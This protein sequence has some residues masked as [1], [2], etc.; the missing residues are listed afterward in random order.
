MHQIEQTV[1]QDCLGRIRRRLY[2]VRTAERAA[3]ALLWG[4]VVG[5]DLVLARYLTLRFP[6]Y[7][8]LV[9]LVPAILVGAFW[10]GRMKYE[11]LRRVSLPFCI[12]AGSGLTVGAV[13]VG[14]G[15]MV[16]GAGWPMW[17]YCAGPLVGFLVAAV[18]MGRVVTPQAA[19]IF[20]DQQ[21]GLQERV[22]TAFELLNK[23]VT[24]VQVAMFQAPL[25]ASAAEACREVRRARVGYARLDRRVYLASAVCMAAA[26]GVSFM[27][28]LSALGARARVTRVD[29]ATAQAVTKVA[30]MLD[31]LARRSESK[32]PA[33][34][35]MLVPLE[36]VLPALRNGELSK[37]EAMSAL[38]EAQREYEKLK[39]KYESGNRAKEAMDKDAALKE[40]AKAADDYRKALDKSREGKPGAAAEL[41]QAKRDLEAAAKAAGDKLAGMSAEERAKLEQTLKEAQAAA[42][43]NAQLEKELGEAREA[44]KSGDGA[45]LGD[46]LKNAGG[47][48]GAQMAEGGAN[49]PRVT[50]TVKAIEEAAKQMAGTGGGQQEGNQGPSDGQG[51][52]NGEK[53]GEGQQ[54]N[55][56][57]NPGGGEPGGEGTSPGAGK[58]MQGT[59]GSEESTSLYAPST[60]GTD[61]GTREIGGA[62]TMVRI[63]DPNP[64]ATAGAQ[65]QVKGNLDKTAATAGKME[66][67]GP[68]DKG[69]APLVP[70]EKMLDSIKKD[71]LEQVE[72]G[73]I[74][75]QYRDVVK[76]MYG[77]GK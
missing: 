19:A 30:A 71:A 18:A 70:Y 45:R 50:D 47:E 60:S 3:I 67:A 62:G 41:E 56:G 59:K 25:V 21:A 65:D 33:T 76:A 22:S 72:K 28:P 52:Q 61:P 26:V 10:V 43:G 63:Y 51:N 37:F 49:S 15:A 1:I 75:P 2:V 8:I 44:A 13:A 4:A 64:I 66:Y 12:H 24:N 9:G 29:A 74:P 68:A 34:D 57:G 69:G 36:T 6:A 16:S 73:Q 48:M 27:Q 14:I 5:A 39:D 53:N 55:K 17:V 20:V 11:M 38:K 58:G 46:S 31:E 77:S 35:P 42:K 23:P 7:A 54:A 40:L 32:N